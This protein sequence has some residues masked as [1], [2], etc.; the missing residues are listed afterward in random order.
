MCGVLSLLSVARERIIY[1]DL[2][3]NIY[4]YMYSYIHTYIHVRMDIRLYVFVYICMYVCMY[5][6]VYNSNTLELDFSAPEVCTPLPH[7]FLSITQ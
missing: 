1:I 4:T 6:Y 7:Y 3:K 2:N 5:I